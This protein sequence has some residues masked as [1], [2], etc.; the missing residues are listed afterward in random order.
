MKTILYLGVIGLLALSGNAFATD[1]KAYNGTGCDNY[2]AADSAQFNHQNDGIKNISGA[3][4]Y[5]SCPIV[6]DEIASTAGT[7]AVYVRWAGTGSFSCTLL[8]YDINGVL[9]QY[10]TASRSGSGWLTMPNLTAD[11]YWGN[12]S[13]WCYLPAGGVL[14]TYWIDEK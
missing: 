3:G 7:Q 11:D 6:V 9:K 1:A 14:Q 5:V 4:R 2:F 8:N 10:K 13:M 12:Y